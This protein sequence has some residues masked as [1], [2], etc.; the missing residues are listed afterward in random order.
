MRYVPDL[1]FKERAIGCYHMCKVDAESLTDF[2]YNEIKVIG[3]DWS[4]GV[5][6]CCDG[7]SV[8]SRHFSGVQVRLREK[9]PQA[10][11]THCYSH[12]LILVIGDCMQKIRTSSLF[13]VLH[14]LQFHLQQQH[15][16]PVVHRGPEN[17][18][19]AC[20]NA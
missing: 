15:S 5:W 19:C 1:K 16:I 7:A 11:Y 10:V 20:A 17:C 9:A 4:K 2:I 8:M 12:K 18:Q 6:Q 13:S 14:S 3:L